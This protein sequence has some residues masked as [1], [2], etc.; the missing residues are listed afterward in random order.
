MYQSTDKLVSNEQGVARDG[1]QSVEGGGPVGGNESNINEPPPTFLAAVKKAR[2]E[3]VGCCNFCMAFFALLIGSIVWTIVLIVIVTVPIV[4][5]VI[6]AE[7]FHDCPVQKMIP[8][9]VI[10]AGCVALL[11]NVMNLV[12]RFKRFSETGMPKRHTVIG[13][14]NVILNLFLFAWFVAACYWVY[15]ADVQFNET[16]KS[17]YC[18]P[19]LYGF[20]YWLLNFI[21]IFFG[22]MVVISA[23]VMCFALMCW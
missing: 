2:E 12:D 4:M 22:A 20:A 17:N 18:N 23:I 21:F 10:V 19:H 8:I 9:S 13:W 7:Y 6:G 3:N 14:V 15:S 11:S 5:I 1:Y 16:N